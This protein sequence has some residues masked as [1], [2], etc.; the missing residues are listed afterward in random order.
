MY[1][2][3]KEK[4]VNPIS[5]VIILLALSFGVKLFIGCTP[6]S[7]S[8]I[9]INFNKISVV[10]VDNSGRFMDHYNAID[11]FYSDAVA[12]KLTLSDTSMYFAASYSSN[13]MQLFSFQSAQAKS[14]DP[15]FVP[16][17]KVVD[18][19]V[20][21]LL[22]INESIKAGDDISEYILYSTRDNFEMYHNLS[23]GISWLNGI[24][25][26]ENSSVFL[27]LKT[28]VK[29]TNAQFEV[30]VTLDNGDELICKTALF[31]ILES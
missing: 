20:S 30:V 6:N 10:G 25:Y 28:G 26:Y 3:K 16:L 2:I 12:L 31:T 11:T 5:P 23:K 8:P 17:N 27:V 7:Q 22:D 15:G 4:K 13:F 14:L 9:D 19:K 29:N 24:Q 18:I 1:K 21:T